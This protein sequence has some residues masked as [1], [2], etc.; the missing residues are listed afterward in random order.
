MLQQTQA[1][2]VEPIYSSFLTRFPSP[3]ALAAAS[4]AEVVWAWAGLGY[5]RRAVALHAAARMI[6]DE[7][8]GHV[9][10]DP[11]TLR[12]LPGVGPYTAAAVGSIA[13]GVPVAAVDT[14]VRR[15]VARVGHGAEPDEVGEARLAMEAGT[16]LDPREPGG[17]NEAMM[18]LGREH[19]R[20]LPRCGGCPLR[21]CC[22]FAGL[23]RVGR[24][25][26]SRQQRF[27]G[28]NRQARGRVVAVLRERT[29]AATLSQ[30]VRFTGIGD[31]H[32]AAAIDGLVADG[33]AE[34]TAAGRFRLPR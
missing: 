16:W 20:T 32:V 5:Q 2:R 12:A 9:P 17:W 18:D 15:I 6:V 24:P 30:L 25:S 33:L 26:S 29:A 34:R 11:R 4:R 1:A 21:P 7:H 22:R 28:S 13:Y 14:N 31:D 27:E 10:G 19:C 3:A 8:G 23:G